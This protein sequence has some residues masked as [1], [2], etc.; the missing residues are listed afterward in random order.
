MAPRA[1]GHVSGYRADMSR[2]PVLLLSALLLLAAC[3]ATPS[4]AT[5]PTEACDP[6]GSAPATY[7]GWPG[8]EPEAS[9]TTELVPLLVSSELAVGQNRFL[10]T[11][12]DGQNRLVAAPEVEVDVRFFDLAADPETPVT[13][14]TAGY[15]QAEEDRGLYRTTVDFTCSGTWGAELTARTPDRE[16]RQARVVFSVRP[17]SSTPEIGA[18]VPATDTPTADSVEAIGRISTDVDPDPDFY[19]LSVA[20]ALE[21]QEPFALIFATPAFCQTRACGPTLDIV[22]DV[23]ADFKDEL[24]FIHVEPYQLETT[25]AGLQPVLSEAGGFQ[26]VPSVVEWGLLSE[27]YIFVV[28]D[29]G[30]LAAKF[31]GVAGADELREAFQAVSAD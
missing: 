4:D 1:F 24:A 12:I 17:E 21:R 31:E 20:E 8:A 3:S 26:A 15:L 25:D 2:S 5:D 9:T 10:F 7:P 28:D 29:D 30:T 27:P 11:L 6:S 16:Q 19:R 13:E 22:R 18:T 14:S 23:A